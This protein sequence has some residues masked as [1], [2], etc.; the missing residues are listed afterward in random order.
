MK[1]GQNAKGL[2]WTTGGKKIK[3]VDKKKSTGLL[4]H[5]REIYGLKDIFYGP[6]LIMGMD[7]IMRRRRENFAIMDLE[8]TDFH[9]KMI[10]NCVGSTKNLPAA[11]STT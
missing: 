10:E 7:G 5:A 11:L 6:K 9:R 3:K 4:Y 8:N 2:S 1:Y